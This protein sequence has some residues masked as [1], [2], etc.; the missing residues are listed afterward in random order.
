[1]YILWRSWLAGEYTADSSAPAALPRHLTYRN[2]GRRLR[3][4]SVNII[5]LVN[6][7]FVKLKL[8]LM[9]RVNNLN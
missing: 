1:M 8:K 5:Y 3:Q 4:T 6:C 7:P 2:R 9:E